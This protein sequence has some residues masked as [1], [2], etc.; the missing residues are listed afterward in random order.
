M[1]IT[2]IFHSLQGEGPLIGLPAS[3]IRFTGCL[4]PYCP[5]CDTRYALHESTEMTLGQIVD[6]LKNY[7]GK[8]VVITG[9]EPFLQW[10]AGL[11][12]LHTELIRMGYAIQYETSGKTGLPMIDDAMVVCSPKFID[13]T[14][15]FDPSNLGKVHYYKFL[16]GNHESLTGILSFIHE[17]AIAAGQ[18]YV[19]PIGMTRDEQLRTME[20]VF[21][22]CRD[23]GYRMTPRLHILTF[24]N[25]RGV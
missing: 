6:E 11:S 16:A 13:S 8:T 25:R 9:G 2:E 17:N 10:D 21:D 22:F 7:P 18:V 19:M 5:W 15:R 1:N 23:N 3:F 20:M 14:W 4:E 24:D 12:E